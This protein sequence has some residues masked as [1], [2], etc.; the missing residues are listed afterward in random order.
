M[1]AWVEEGSN[2]LLLL[3]L[4]YS[5][6]YS[7]ILKSDYNRNHHHHHHASDDKVHPV[8]GIESCLSF[9]HDIRTLLCPSSYCS[10]APS[11]EHRAPSTGS[12]DSG[13]R[14]SRLSCSSKFDAPPPPFFARSRCK[15]DLPSVEP[16]NEEYDS[17]LK[18]PII[19]HRIVII[20]IYRQGIID[21]ESR[22]A[23]FRTAECPRWYIRFFVEFGSVRIIGE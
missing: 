5:Y 11:T 8:K 9:H 18:P 2:C 19:I 17:Q 20:I 4:C 13:C 1:D 3:C 15:K 14:L 21:V 22:Y 23:S 7:P 16:A 6:Y 10:L 12:T